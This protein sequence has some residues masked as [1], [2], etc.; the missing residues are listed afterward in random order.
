MILVLKN[1]TEI[2]VL[3]KSTV[4]NIIVDCSNIEEVDSITQSLCVKGNLDSFKFTADNGD[5]YG[6]YENFVY[7]STN[8]TEEEG[9]YNAIFSIRK[10]TDIE[11][12][13]DA[14]ES[15]QELQNGAIDELASIVGGEV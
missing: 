10:K 3:D 2:S 8:Y 13:L 1:N 12:R 5:T 4:Y 15:E 9:I 7:V 6:E 11:I 14:L